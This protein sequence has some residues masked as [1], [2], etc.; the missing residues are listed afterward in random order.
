MVQAT[1]IAIIGAGMAWSPYLASLR[2]LH[3]AIEVAWIVGRTRERVDAA[4]RELPG[5]RATTS[6]AD[7][8]DDRSVSAVF[9]L[10]PP[11]THG[12]VVARVAAAGKHVLL[13]KP[14]ERDAMRRR[15]SGPPRRPAA[16]TTGPFARSHRG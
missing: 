6:L 4:A 12:D 8:L 2:E 9:V 13:E 5:A 10:T 3:S 15:T 14:L 7:A 11:N 1:R 16:R